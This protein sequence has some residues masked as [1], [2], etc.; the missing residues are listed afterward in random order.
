[1]PV[2]V[3]IGQ[4][5]VIRQGTH[6]VAFLPRTGRT[7]Y[8]CN[9][10]SWAEADWLSR[11]RQLVAGKTALIITHCFTTAGQANII[12]VMAEGRIVESGSH[13]GL[14]AQ[15]GRY[16]QSWREQVRGSDNGSSR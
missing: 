15:D 3:C 5:V 4:S 9:M 2:R 6:A 10:D 7:R 12:H 11:F 1:M 14:L 13:E 16:A 8:R